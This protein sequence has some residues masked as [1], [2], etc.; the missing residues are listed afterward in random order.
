VKTT[1]K[2]AKTAE[3]VVKTVEKNEKPEFKFE[4]FKPLGISGFR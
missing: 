4:N 3:T 1:E 2:V